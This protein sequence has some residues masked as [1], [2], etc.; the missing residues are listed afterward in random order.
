MQHNKLKRR[1]FIALLSTAAVPWPLLVAVHAQPV[2]PVLGFLHSGSPQ[3]YAHLVAAFRRG[4]NQAGYTEGRNVMIEYRWA[5]NQ[6]DRLPGLVADLVRRNPAA[7]AACG[8]AAASAAK[9]GTATIP[10]AF[11]VGADPVRLGL[12]A[13]LNRPAGNLT[14]VSILINDLG[15]KQVELLHELIPKA[16]LIGVLVNPDSPS[17]ENDINEILR[18]VRVLGLAAHVVK[19]RT[20][21]DIAAAFINLAQNRVE[22][23]IV[24]SDVSMFDRRV[25]I[26]ALAAQHGVP[27]IY[28]LRDFTTAGG[29]MSY[30]SDIVEGYRQQGIFAGQVLKGVTPADLPVQ[31]S[32]KLDLV[33]NLQTAKMLG[34]DVPM[35]ILMRVN[36]VIE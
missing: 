24:V 5:E 28:P 22:G 21:G 15:P 36:D 1:E 18:A 9:L 17:T 7:I 30:G 3:P 23:L 2:I 11:V 27:A 25:E 34:L 10:V 13:S 14:G 12:V 16:R 33:V 31:Q 6:N 29:L 19:A 26:A 35:S 4:L 32:T 20:A 8:P